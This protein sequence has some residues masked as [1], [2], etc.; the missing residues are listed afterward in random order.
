ML[1]II[2][3]KELQQKIG[4]ISAKINENSYIITNRGK[5]KM[6]LLPYFEGCEDMTEDFIEDCEMCMNKDKLEKQFKESL[7]SGESDLVI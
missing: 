2:T 1:K 4:Q 5:A 7:D 6:I 3:V